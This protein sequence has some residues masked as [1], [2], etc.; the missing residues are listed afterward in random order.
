MILRIW[1][2]PQVTYVN[3]CTCG[4]NEI[5]LITINQIM[6]ISM[7]HIHWI[8]ISPDQ[9]RKYKHLDRNVSAYTEN[10][11]SN[12]IPNP[13]RYIV[14]SNMF[15]SSPKLEHQCVVDKV[16]TSLFYYKTQTNFIKMRSK[17]T[18]R[19]IR[20]GRAEP[21]ALYKLNSLSHVFDLRLFRRNLFS[22]T[23]NRHRHYSCRYHVFTT[24]ASYADSSNTDLVGFDQNGTELM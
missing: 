22:S 11:T 18:K 10:E 12:A 23:K 19:R 7:L 20:L 6:A 17:S 14:R 21:L 24:I 15:A 16:W 1:A 13:I 9:F 4:K 5:Y 2:F 8:R 3:Q